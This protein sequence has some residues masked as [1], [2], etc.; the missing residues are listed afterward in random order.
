MFSTSF[1]SICGGMN[2][3]ELS[4]SNTPVAVGISVSIEDNIAW[5]RAQDIDLNQRIFA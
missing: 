2:G 4:G 3:C 5:N 1:S